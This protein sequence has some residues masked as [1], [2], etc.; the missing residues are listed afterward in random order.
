MLVPI[1]LA[2][3]SPLHQGRSAPYVVGALAGVVLLSLLLTQPLLAIGFNLNTSLACA[4]KWHQWLG[5]AIV[6]LIALHIGGL[7]LASPMD[8][9]DALTLAA[10]TPFS[11]YGVIGL[12]ASVLIVFSLL[13]RKRTKPMRWN[14]IHNVLALL[15]VVPGV[16]H[17]LLIEGSMEVRTK[18]ILCIVIVLAST[19]VSVKLRI[20]DPFKRGHKTNHS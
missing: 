10:P 7:Y 16:V 18:W 9:L 8:M 4:R 20:V 15:V 11:L 12:W 14:T 5:G 13:I 2:V 19:L 17:A 3:M 6:V 1:V